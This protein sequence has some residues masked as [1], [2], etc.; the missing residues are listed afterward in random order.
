MVQVVNK[1]KNYHMGKE[2]VI[3]TDHQPLQYSWAQ[4]K[5]QPT[6][7]YKWMG[8]LQQFH[9]V[10]K[11]KK[12]STN[13]LV[14]ILSR[15]PTSNL[16]V[17]GTLMYLDPFTHDSYREAY[18]EDENFKEVFHQLHSQSHVHDGDNKIDQNLQD[19]LLYML[20]KLCLPKG[21]RDCK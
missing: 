13:K 18:S 19:G 11:Y 14:E 20:D 12:G 21:E 9:L 10:I 5:R 6:R 16:T 2:I 1:Q 15:P 3:H 7:N 17:L 8:F 4:I